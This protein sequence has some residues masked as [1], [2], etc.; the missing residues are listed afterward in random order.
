MVDS[1]L[2]QNLHFF[3]ML[4]LYYFNK[5]DKQSVNA[6]YIVKNIN[7]VVLTDCLWLLFTGNT[8]E[9][10][11]LKICTSLHCFLCL[12]PL[13]K[14]Y[15][16]LLKISIFV[17]LSSI[18]HKQIV[19]ELHVESMAFLLQSVYLNRIVTVTVFNLNVIGRVFLSI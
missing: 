12:L 17:S 4:R 7:T 11:L 8:T 9:M 1:I 18:H 13:K 5:T 3:I 16:I 2:C 15:F 19:M 6:T 14:D 10:N